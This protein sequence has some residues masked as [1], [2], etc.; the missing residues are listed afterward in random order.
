MAWGRIGRGA[1]EDFRPP[2]RQDQLEKCSRILQNRFK[3]GANSLF[4]RLLWG[5]LMRGLRSDKAEG[6]KVGKSLY[7]LDCTDGF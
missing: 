1:L 7:F 6:R 3:A 4:L 5:D 2:E